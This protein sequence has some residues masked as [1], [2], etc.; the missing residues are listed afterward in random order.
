MADRNIKSSDPR[1]Y[2]LP[3]SVCLFFRKKGSVA[4]ADWKSVGNVID[5]AIA[6]EIERL[7]HFSQRRGKRA[8]D[9]EVISERAAT[10]NFSIDE[11]NRDTLEWMFGNVDGHVDSTVR[12]RN[13]GVFVNPGG[14]FSIDLGPNADTLDAA[15]VVV[16]GINLEPAAGPTIY[17][18]PAAYTVDAVNGEIDIVL[19]GPLTNPVTVPEVHVFWEKVVDTQKFEV[20]S[21]AAVEGEAQFQVMTPGG[22]QYVLTMKSVSIINNGDITIGD[23][24]AFQEVPLSLSIL[25]DVNG[26][27]GELHIVD[28]LA[29]FV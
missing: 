26:K 29:S 1:N 21:G 9:R 22:I 20:F 18:T 14:S 11:I 19:A 25:V 2:Q 12:T 8:K 13:E 6:A 15:S 24:T 4:N 3:G 10:L 27:L 17:A 7:E 16:R 28:E 23:G 5:P